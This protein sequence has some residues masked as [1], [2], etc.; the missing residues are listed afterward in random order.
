MSFHMCRHAVQVE[1]KCAFR[2]VAQRLFSAKPSSTPVERIWNG[3][4]DTITAKRRSMKDSMLSTLVY[5]RT[6]AGLLANDFLPEDLEA[7]ESTECFM[8]LFDA[9]VELDDQLDAQAAAAARKAVGEV[10]DGNGQDE[11]DGEED[12]QDEEDELG[13]EDFM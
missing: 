10:P 7:L 4:G 2:S 3:F 9:V 5:A 11:P 6:N 1:D 13:L 8:S 12:V